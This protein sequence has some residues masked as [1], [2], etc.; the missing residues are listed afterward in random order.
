MVCWHSNIKMAVFI[1][2]TPSYMFVFTGCSDTSIGI[3]NVNIFPNNRFTATS[4]LDSRYVP[5]NA[6]LQVN[7]RGWGA[8]TNTH[9]NDH[10]QID[11]GSVYTICAIATQGSA[12]ASEWVRDYLIMTS[13]NGA[14]YT[15]YREN[16]ADKVD[17]VTLLF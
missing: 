7:V 6:R 11:L 10:L 15:T 4:S 14:R 13:V 17:C 2:M 9:A 12:A 3:E 8:S 5:S 1:N 16:G